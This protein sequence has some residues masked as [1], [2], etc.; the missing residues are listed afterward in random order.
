[1]ADAIV[2][3]QVLRWISSDFPGWIE[4]GLG[5]A[6]GQEHRIVEKVRVLTRR[7]VTAASTFPQEFWIQAE[8][9]DVRGERVL[10]TF[11]DAVETTEGRAS[12]QMRAADVKWL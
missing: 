10:V 6:D 2:R 1:M 5:D 3:A 12:V 8:T 7:G 9:G 11:A 4:V